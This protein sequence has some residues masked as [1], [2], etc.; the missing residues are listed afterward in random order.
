LEGLWTKIY[1]QKIILD[2]L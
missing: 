1:N 2:Y